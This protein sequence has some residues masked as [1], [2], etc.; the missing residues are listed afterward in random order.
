MPRKEPCRCSLGRDE[1][2]KGLTNELCFFSWFQSAVKGVVTS[3]NQTHLE[4]IKLGTGFPPLFLLRPNDT[5]QSVLAVLSALRHLLQLI[6]LC[7]RLYVATQTHHFV[8]LPFILH[9]V[10]GFILS[11]DTQ[12]PSSCLSNNGPSLVEGCAPPLL[13]FLLWSGLW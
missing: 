4:M 9:T 8:A 3:L 5:W 7:P 6:F 13:C 11:F 1:L 12:H 10:P 2:I